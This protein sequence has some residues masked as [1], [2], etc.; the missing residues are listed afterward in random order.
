MG[1]L[2]S[3]CLKVSLADERSETSLNTL[4]MYVY[5]VCP[6]VFFHVTC[7]YIQFSACFLDHY[8]SGTKL[9]KDAIAEACF[10]DVINLYN[11]SAKY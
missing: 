8:D 10:G 7:S 6:F 9:Q 11:A 3:L 1:V 4:Y 2:W 5:Y